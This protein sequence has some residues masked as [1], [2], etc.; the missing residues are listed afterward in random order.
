[1][2]NMSLSIPIID[3]QKFPN[4]EEYKKLREACDEWGC[5]RVMNHSLPKNLMEEM[6]KV[7]T[8]LHDRPREIKKRNADVAKGSGYTYLPINPLYENMGFHD[9][10]SSLDIDSFCFQLEA[11]PHDK[12]IIKAY[13]EAIQELAVDIA[14]KIKECVV[15]LSEVVDFQDW[16]CNFKMN[17]YSFTL[18]TIGL[19]GV[20]EHTD[21]GFLT[22]VQDD[23]LIDG[24]EV[25]H[26]PS[27]SFVPVPPL[28]GTFVVNLGDVAHVWSNG[29]F[30]NVHHR[31]LCKEGRTRIS[32]VASLQAPRHRD[33]EVAKEFVDTDHPPLFMPFNF[34]RYI[35][36][37]WSKNMRVG[38]ALDLLRVDHP[39]NTVSA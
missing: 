2:V 23:D 21:P 29:R 11:S 13:G 15:G 31:V 4:E 18:E 36:S 34:E 7:A 26:L 16:R 6:K 3:M 10:G 1:M 22:V 19:S 9:F 24:L 28:S 8:Y 12:E 14:R 17:K 30:P 39:S 20:H 38:E 25:L 33:V 27:G 35:E 5:F 37:R 32:V